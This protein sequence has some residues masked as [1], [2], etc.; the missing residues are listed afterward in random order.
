MR[1]NI[2]NSKNG[3]Q[4]NNHELERFSDIH[5]H[6]LA[7][8]DDG[9]STIK[10]SIELCRM[11][12]VEGITTVVATPH[13]LG[14]FENFNEAANV[15][16]AVKILNRL[17]IKESIP[18]KIFPG[19][20]VRVDE[21]ICKFLESDKI[22]TLAD[23]GKYLLI[24]LPHGIFINVEPLLI[25]LATIDIQPIISH[26]E[27]IASIS[28]NSNSIS[29][30]LDKKA[31]LQITASGL[32]G[33]FGMET[34]QIAWHFLSSGKATIVATDSH[35][36]DSRKPNMKTA[37]KQISDKLGEELAHL[38]CVENPLRIINGEDILP[39]SLCN[40]KELNR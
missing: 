33:D 37:F 3:N 18:I 29:H 2:F 6:C 15:R 17:L 21:R 8:F 24:E 19:G 1:D 4:S 9:P 5:C 36:T 31:H 32:L 23:G 22:L 34:Q 10:E 26:A 38:V 35:N 40:K 11:L 28:A 16:E 25:D 39:I 14:R 20:E 7:G 30:W 13:Q 27:R 12:A